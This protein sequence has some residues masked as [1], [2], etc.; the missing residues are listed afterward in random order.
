MESKAEIRSDFTWVTENFFSVSSIIT[1]L[2]TNSKKRKVRGGNTSLFHQKTYKMSRRVEFFLC[3]HGRMAF[4][5]CDVLRKGRRDFAHFMASAIAADVWIHDEI[6][7]IAEIGE[8]ALSKDLRPSRLIIR[9]S[10]THF[11]ETCLVFGVG[12]FEFC[13]L[14]CFAVKQ[15]VRIL[16]FKIREHCVFLCVRMQSRI[17]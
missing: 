4:F 16:R 17:G 8:R 10:E 6:I 7:A 11:L 12:F 5:G 9:P 13:L 15:I 14:F 1:S 2:F 3:I